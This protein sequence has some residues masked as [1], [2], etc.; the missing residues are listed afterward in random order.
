M[1]HAKC[2]GTTYAGTIPTLAM[3]AALLLPAQQAPGFDLRDPFGRKTE[4]GVH[5]RLVPVLSV[6]AQHPDTSY[7]G[8]DGSYVMQRTDTLPALPDGATQWVI[9]ESVDRTNDGVSV[10]DLVRL[11]HCRHRPNQTNTNTYTSTYGGYTRW[12]DYREPFRRLIN[13]LTD[14]YEGYEGMDSTEPSK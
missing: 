11:T 5:K 1:K 3:A 8:A 9:V 14:I 6:L 2:A 4:D 12:I 13:M 7:A 10:D